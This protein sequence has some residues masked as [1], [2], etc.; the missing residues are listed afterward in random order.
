MTAYIGG[1]QSTECKGCV[2]AELKTKKTAASVDDFLNGVADAGQREDAFQLV[3][4]MKEITGE[5]PRMWG[6]TIVGFGEYHYVYE[7]GHEGDICLAGFS[8]RKGNLTLYFGAG[9]D[10]FGDLLKKLGKC[11]ISKGCV[12]VK[13]LADIDLAVLRDLIECNIARLTAESI[14]A[15][16]P[17]RKVAKKS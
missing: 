14:A 5:A 8:P 11:K 9:F 3:K 12:Y 1:E 17:A 7:S 10:E 4:L 13:K 16:K 2:M 15:K 6:P